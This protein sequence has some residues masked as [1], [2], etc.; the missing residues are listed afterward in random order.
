MK[1]ILAGDVPVEVNTRFCNLTLKKSLLQDLGQELISND[2]AKFAL[3]T[4]DE[5][6]LSY[7]QNGTER[8]SSVDVKVSWPSFP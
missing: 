1:K 7:K 4:L 8:Y 5:M 2:K 6:G 3:P